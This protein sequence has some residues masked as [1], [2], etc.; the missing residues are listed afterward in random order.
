MKEFN[1]NS[2]AC[3]NSHHIFLYQKFRSLLHRTQCFKN[4]SNVLV[5]LSGGVDSSVLLHLLSEYQKNENGPKVIALHINHMQR[6]NESECDEA[7]ARATAQQMGCAYVT[8][9]LEN[10]TRDMSEEQL[11]KLRHAT[12]EQVAKENNCEAIALGHHLDDQAETFLFR[13]IRGADIKGLSSMKPFR[14]PYVRPLLEISRNEI[15]M[16]AERCN[17]SFVSDSSNVLNGPARNFIRNVVMPALESKLDPQVKT[18]MADLAN[19]MSEIDLY[20]TAQAVEMIKKVRVEENVYSVQKL[21]GVPV[22]LRKKMIH[23]MYT[24]I[25]KDKGSLSRDHVEMINGWMES[26]Q[27]PKYLQLPN[28]IRVD[29][30]QSVLTFGFNQ[31]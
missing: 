17:I 2:N 23:L 14:S 24:H 12:L 7:A 9:T 26:T 8:V 30:K 31:A 20:M 18:H 1:R 22:A 6:A 13:L 25:I 4:V 10:A 15:L 11:R 16:E 21:Q 5:G 3:D 28:N 19:S 29:K 27:S